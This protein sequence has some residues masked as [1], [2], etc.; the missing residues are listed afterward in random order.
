MNSPLENPR[1]WFE[2]VSAINQHLI[3]RVV[4]QQDAGSPLSARILEIPTALAEGYAG[5]GARWRE[6]Q[7]EYARKQWRLLANLMRAKTDEPAPVLVEPETGDRRFHDRGWRELAFFDYVKQSY[8]IGAE[9]LAA[10]IESAELDGEKKKRLEFYAQQYLDAMSPSNFLATNPEALELAL[11]T[12][13]ESVMRGMTN[14]AN[15]VERG[16][17]SMS[18]ESAFEVGRNLAITAGAVV[19]E[20]QYM[21]L[22]QYTPLTEQ[23]YRRPLLIVPPFINKYY[24]LDLQPENSFVRHALENG[25]TVFMISWRNITAELGGATWDDYI[26]HAVVKAMAVARDIVRADKMNALGFCVGGTLLATALAVQRAKRK[27]PVASLT[28]LTTMLDFTDTGKISV[29]VDDAY[30]NEC[31]TKYRAG[32]VMPGAELASS[33]ASLR[34]NELIW[35]YVVNNYLKGHSPRS[36]DLLFWNADSANLPGA[37]YAYYIKNMYRDNNLKTPGK[38]SMCKAPVDLGKIDVPTYILASREDHIVPWQSAYATTKLI[39]GKVEFTLAAS[40]HI[41]GVINPASKNKRNYWTGRTL[42]A[43]S[44]QWLAHAE[45]VPGSW[46]P[47]WSAWLARQA[48]KPVT[49]PRK[50]GNAQYQQIEAA[51]GRYV[52]AAA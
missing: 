30:V 37:L 21:Q 6:I 18:D 12:E 17:I 50:P 46:W 10:L 5:N 14:L 16:R 41:A 19:F 1:A 11:K 23:V 51:P 38:L 20:N 31:Q 45:S 35:F 29:Y 25:H 13:G 47:H 7:T 2:R 22:I 24:I 9:W 26:E 36:F 34:A 28:L 32:G 49:A 3:D 44:E 48:G 43:N 27:N 52:K 33:F 42:P 4:A 39:S 15:D 8:L 40:G